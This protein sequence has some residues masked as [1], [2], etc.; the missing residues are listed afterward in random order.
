MYSHTKWMIHWSEA[1][2]QVVPLI[3]EETITERLLIVNKINAT[4]IRNP[5]TNYKV[6]VSV[7][8]R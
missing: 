1:E 4:Q 3:L 6:P 8:K 7:E 2:L 5:V